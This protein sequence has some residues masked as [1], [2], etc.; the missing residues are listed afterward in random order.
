M[1]TRPMRTIHGERGGGSQPEGTGDG[2]FVFGFA[3]RPDGRIAL[4]FRFPT[5]G[6]FE[7]AIIQ[8]CREHPE[9]C[10]LL[11][12]ALHEGL[13]YDVDFDRTRNGGTQGTIAS[14]AQATE[15]DHEGGP[16][17]QVA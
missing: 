11:F 13:E 17:V 16:R 14:D 1:D 3:R 12:L 8:A 4:V 7:Q 2:R 6:S 15:D 10:R 9:A 5:R